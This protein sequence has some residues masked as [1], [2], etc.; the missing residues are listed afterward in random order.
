MC[1]KGPSLYLYQKL[2][3]DIG[4]IFV[5]WHVTQRAQPIILFNILMYYDDLVKVIEE[6]FFKDMLL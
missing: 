6:D 5:I 4:I 1:S 2:Q 3:V